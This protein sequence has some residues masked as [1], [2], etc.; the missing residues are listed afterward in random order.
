MQRPSSNAVLVP[1]RSCPSLLGGLAPGQQEPQPHSAAA[2]A[3]SGSGFPFLFLSAPPRARIQPLLSMVQGAPG[4]FLSVLWRGQIKGSGFTLCLAL[5]LLSRPGARRGGGSP[6]CCR[7]AAMRGAG[8]TASCQAPLRV[9]AA[10]PRDGNGSCGGPGAAGEHLH[11]RGA[12]PPSGGRLPPR[13]HQRLFPSALSGRCTKSSALKQ[14]AQKEIQGRQLP[15]GRAAPGLC[16]CSSSGL[17]PGRLPAAATAPCGEPAAPGLP[18]RCAW[19]CWSLAPARSRFSRPSSSLP[20][21]PA[22]P[23]QCP[24]ALMVSAS[25]RPQGLRLLA[26][27]QPTPPVAFLMSQNR[28]GRKLGALVRPGAR[29]CW[30]RGGDP[31]PA[32]RLGAELAASQARGLCCA[33]G[34]CPST[35]SL[36]HSRVPLGKRWGSGH[37]SGHGPRPRQPQQHTRVQRRHQ[38][39]M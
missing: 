3:H 4:L 28:L 35:T 37:G 2:S 12:P 20:A 30:S 16:V 5:L 24:A 23:A 25:L 38:N 14:E 36:C 33:P 17:R 6:W 22:L 9:P 1:L 13:E 18:Q 31:A 26:R 7:T 34:P 8:D 21:V 11:P 27:H 32:R 10:A 29:Q 19:C 39:F 15:L